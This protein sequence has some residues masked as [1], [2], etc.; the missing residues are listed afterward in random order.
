MHYHAHCGRSLGGEGLSQYDHAILAEGSPV[1]SRQWKQISL[2]RLS[3]MRL[4]TT[5][6]QRTRSVLRATEIA[7]VSLPIEG[8]SSTGRYDVTIIDSDTDRAAQIGALLRGLGR[9]SI[10]HPSR[11]TAAANALGPLAI[12]IVELCPS[13]APAL[14]WAAHLARR[15]AELVFFAEPKSPERIAAQAV[16]LRPILS[17]NGLTNW[18]PE[19]APA[20]AKRA[21]ARR[22]LDESTSE[23][24]PVPLSDEAPKAPPLLKL[25]V[26]EDRFRESYLRTLLVQ[27]PDR[28][29]AA[30]EASIPYRTLCAML[31]KLQIG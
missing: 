25:T 30:R 8:R 22:L 23:L 9:L 18:L 21:L 7:A 28:K 2:H 20:L 3:D 26:A 19:A 12:G 5:P 29:D 10:E 14:A 4:L 16:G 27:Y 17:F 1:P 15:G 11:S 13:L 6:S 31:Y 24:P